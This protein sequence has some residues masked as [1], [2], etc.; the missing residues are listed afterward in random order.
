M[1]IDDWKVGESVGEWARRKINVWISQNKPSSGWEKG[2]DSIKKLSQEICVGEATI[3]RLK[4]SKAKYFPNKTTREKFCNHLGF[5]GFSPEEPTDIKN[6]SLSFYYQRSSDFSKVHESL[7]ARPNESTCPL[8]QPLSEYFISPFKLINSDGEVPLY[9][10]SHTKKDTFF[11]IDIDT[12]DDIK[13]KYT[14]FVST[15]KDKKYG[16]IRA[17]PEKYF[18]VGFSACGLCMEKYTLLFSCPYSEIL[19][20]AMKKHNISQKIMAN[21]LAV[22]LTTISRLLNGEI[23]FIDPRIIRRIYGVYIL[24]SLKADR[25][26]ETKKRK[27]VFSFLKHMEVCGYTDKNL[28][29]Y[30]QVKFI[31]S[32]YLTAFDRYGLRCEQFLVSCDLLITS[33]NNSIKIACFYNDADKLSNVDLLLAISQN[34]GATHCCLI[35]P[36]F[37]SN[38]DFITLDLVSYPYKNCKLP[39][40]Q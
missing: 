25:R 12:W 26:V 13:Y 31:N 34:Y 38:N 19:S 40:N 3:Y 22:N 1:D 37:L 36:E 10:H 28:Q 6:E 11:E 5:Y 17:E 8:C 15:N 4:K 32:Q 35:S 39:F 18:D 21:E 9:N 30:K 16:T 24:G 29:L 33:D 20:V 2:E 27:F 14:F 23:E 7:V